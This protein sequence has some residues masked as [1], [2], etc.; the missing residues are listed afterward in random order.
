MR[1]RSWR[2]SKGMLTWKFPK[3]SFMLQVASED[4]FSS[5][6]ILKIEVGPQALC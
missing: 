5:G 2:F 6:L 3:T 4:L 1:P